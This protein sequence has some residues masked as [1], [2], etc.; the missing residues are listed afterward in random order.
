MKLLFDENLSSRLVQKL[1]FEYP[2]SNHVRNVGL[3]GK[4]DEQI[5]TF[6]KEQG[7]TIV[8]KD[9][10]FRERSFVEGAPPRIIWLDVGNAGTEEIAVLMQNERQRIDKFNSQAESSLLIL[11]FSNKSI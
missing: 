6:A 11:S 1:A 3:K 10:D 8:S 5:W 7:F 4:T 2:E 9:T